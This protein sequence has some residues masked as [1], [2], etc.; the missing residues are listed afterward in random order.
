MASEVPVLLP[1]LTMAAIEGTFVEWLVADG[2][3]V[4]ED[5]PLYTIETEKVETEVAS[6]ASGVLRHGSVEPGEAYA[7]GTLLGV[8]EQDS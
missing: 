3:R 7:V 8:I 4:A 1:K 6:A 5:D 2:S